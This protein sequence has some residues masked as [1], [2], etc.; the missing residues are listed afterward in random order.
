MSAIPAPMIPLTNG[1]RGETVN[2]PQLGFGT[3]KVP[4]ADT[5]RIVEEGLEVG[6]RHIDTAEMYGNEAGVGKAIAS[7]GIPRDQLFITSKLNNAFHDPKAA[8]KAFDDTMTALGIDVLDLFLVHWPMAK[9][10]S[11]EATWTAMVD[12][13]GSGRVRAVGVSNYQPDHLRTIINATGV[14]PAVNQIEVHPY[15]TQE[16]LREL[17]K[18][19]GIVTEAWSPLARGV[20]LSDPTIDRIAGE[21]S[22][23]ASQVVLRWHIQRGDVVFPKSMHRARMEENAKIFD[24]ELT[25]GQMAEITALNRNERQGSHPDEVQGVK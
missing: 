14:T 19:L 22:R 13:L 25:D 1:T 8:H 15:L 6:Y 5:Q 21:L 24:F 3:Y 4:P 2:I 12:I 16:P 20:V 18:E 11:L 10:T 9:T 7:A 17:D 23:T